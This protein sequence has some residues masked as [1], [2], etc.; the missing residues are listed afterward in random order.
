MVTSKGTEYGVNKDAKGN[1]KEKINIE[2][3][4]IAHAN[5]SELTVRI[6]T[7]ECLS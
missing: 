3:E 1:K 6:S 7:S 2:E 5:C 4:K